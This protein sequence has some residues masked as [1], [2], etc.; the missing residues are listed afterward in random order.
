MN[1]EYLFFIIPVEAVEYTHESVFLLPSLEIEVNGFFSLH[2]FR[3][4]KGLEF[5][6]IIGQTS[7]PFLKI[8]FGGELIFDDLDSVTEISFP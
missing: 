4:V 1:L 6:V 7:L 5:I 8:F 3:P 2:N